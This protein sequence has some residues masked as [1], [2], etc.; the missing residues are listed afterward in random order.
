MLVYKRK[1]SRLAIVCFQVAACTKEMYTHKAE[2]GMMAAHI[3][4]NVQM[5]LLDSTDAQTGVIN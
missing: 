5:V 3:D 2:H 1:R 4:V